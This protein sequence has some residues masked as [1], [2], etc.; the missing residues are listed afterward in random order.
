MPAQK[1][2][3]K[4]SIVLFL[5]G[6]LA[7]SPLTYLWIAKHG[8]SG[9]IWFWLNSAALDPMY[10]TAVFDFLLLMMALGAVLILDGVPRFP[11]TR[12]RWLWIAAWGFLFFM[13]PSLGFLVYI[14]WIKNLPKKG[15]PAIDPSPSSLGD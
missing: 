9:G 3:Q 4:F 15:S 5:I 12:F 11:H 1:C 7:L 8:F 10:A 14:I 13:T 6:I 2:L